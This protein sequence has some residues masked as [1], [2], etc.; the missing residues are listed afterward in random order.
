MTDVLF[1]VRFMDWRKGDKV[2]LKKRLADKY[3]G[4]G[5]CEKVRIPAKRKSTKPPSNK[6]AAAPNIK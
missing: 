5:V 1:N 3:I 6:R 4:M 2:E